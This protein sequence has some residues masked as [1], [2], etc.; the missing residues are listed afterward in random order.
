MLSQW[1]SFYFPI[2]FPAR[3]ANT[4]EFINI[5]QPIA[6]EEGL[7][8]Y[9][10]VRSTATH[11]QFYVESVSGGRN[12]HFSSNHTTKFNISSSNEDKEVRIMKWEVLIDGA[13]VPV[14][15]GKTAIK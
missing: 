13:E 15:V 9:V 12:F 10:N 5:W 2:H 7:Q 4:F 11:D 14:C 6:Q 1:Y 8:I 3:A